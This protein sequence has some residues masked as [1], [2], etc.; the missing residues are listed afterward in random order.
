MKKSP[1]G[2]YFPKS[3]FFFF[4]FNCVHTVLFLF[5]VSV[6]LN[7]ANCFF[8]LPNNVLLNKL[9]KTGVFDISNKNLCLKKYIIH[10]GA[11]LHDQ[12]FVGQTITALKTAL[13][14]NDGIF[15]RLVQV[16]NILKLDLNGILKAS[17][18]LAKSSVNV[19]SMLL[20]KKKIP[21]TRS[22]RQICIFK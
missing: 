10:L 21:L 3:F 18:K 4:N 6:K 5:D 9:N 1:K 12:V 20:S 7:N 19:C 15:Y 22:W 17:T 2:V 8:F 14:C 13:R 16:G 11:L